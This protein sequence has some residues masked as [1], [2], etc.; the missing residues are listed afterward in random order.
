[1]TKTIRNQQKKGTSY[2]CSICLAIDGIKKNITKC[3]SHNKADYIS[4]IKDKKKYYQLANIAN[5]KY[6][7]AY[8]ELEGACSFVTLM[9]KANLQ[10]TIIRHQDTPDTQYIFPYQYF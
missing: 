9:L 7:E 1:M 4:Q 5:K 3:T 6:Q 8:E 10:S 2:N